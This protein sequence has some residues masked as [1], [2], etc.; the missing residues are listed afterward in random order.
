MNIPTKSNTYSF[1]LNDIFKDKLIGLGYTIREPQI[2][3]VQHILDYLEN[4]KKFSFVK[5]K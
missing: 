2:E 1:I 4:T 5:L 3:L